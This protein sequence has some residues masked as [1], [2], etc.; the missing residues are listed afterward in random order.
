MFTGEET[1][2]LG[3]LA[4]RHTTG[5]NWGSEGFT[6]VLLPLARYWWTWLLT[7]LRR[8]GTLGILL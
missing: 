5:V 6:G 1:E 8:T 7:V 3:G 2:A 4:C